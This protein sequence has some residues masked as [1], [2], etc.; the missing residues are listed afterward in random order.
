MLKAAK[1]GGYFAA[2][3][4]WCV[5][6][7]ETLIPML[8]YADENSRKMERLET[9]DIADSVRIG[10]DRLASNEMGANVAALLYDARIPVGDE[11][12]DAIVVEFRAYSA[13]KAALT[14]ALPYTPSTDTTIFKVHKP[15]I[16]QWENCDD[17]DLTTLMEEFFKGSTEHEKGSELW[18]LHL[19]ESK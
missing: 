19:D 15:K 6:D 12:L 10:K 16:L 2:H 4:I 17:F 3:A 1:F 5:G 18:N 11:K 9:D 7:G 8:A 13:P 14:V